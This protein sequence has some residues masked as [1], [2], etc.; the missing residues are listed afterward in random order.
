MS[1]LELQAELRLPARGAGKASRLPALTS[2]RFFAAAMIVAYH[3]HACALLPGVP[4]WLAALPLRQG[5]SFFFVLSGFILTYVYGGLTARG[6]PGF[7]RARW[8]RIWPAHLAALGL[9]LLVVPGELRPLSAPVLQTMANVG[10]VHA[11]IPSE[12]YYFSFNAVSWSIS[13]EFAFYLMFPLLLWKLG[14]AW[15]VN[16]LVGAGLLLAMVA[17]GNHLAAGVQTAGLS[18]ADFDYRMEKELMFAVYV[19]PLARVLEFIVGMTTAL[20]FARFGTRGPAGRGAATVVEVGAVGLVVAGL[21]AS[22]GVAEALL[23]VV[24]EA[25]RIWLTYAGGSMLPVAVLIFVMAQQ[26]GWVSR[27]LAWPVLVW[28]GEI[29]YSVYLVHQLL[30]RYMELHKDAAGAVPA[31]VRWVVYGVTVVVLASVIWLLVERPLRAVLTGKMGW[32]A[33]GRWFWPVV[34]VQLAWLAGVGCGA[35]WLVSR[36]VAGVP[37]GQVAALEAAGLKAFAGV[38][39]G[40]RVELRALV[41]EEAAEGRV[42]VRMLWKSLREQRRDLMVAVH[43]MDAKGE[44]FGNLD[45]PQDVEQ[46]AAAVGAM[47][48]SEAV[49]GAEQRMKV[50]HIGVGVYSAATGLLKGDRGP[51][52]WDGKRLLVPIPALKERR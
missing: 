40:E 3:A 43:L 45:H 34:A 21:V 14:K 9:F 23:P 47:W 15:W 26:R 12:S 11:W 2:L 18:A 39:F 17:W 25:G 42:V 29:S 32:K 6:L 48:V 52:D 33:R 10:M 31:G 8:A 51:S 1:T 30:L 46:H 5:V 41:V 7:W 4:E 19:N 13:T 24:G 50:D 16:L 22:R 35:Q 36:D 27:V 44:V 37:A 28:L 38:R 20:A 49:I